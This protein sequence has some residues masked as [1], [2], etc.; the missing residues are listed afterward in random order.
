MYRL[1]VNLKINKF[2]KTFGLFM[3]LFLFIT[4]VLCFGL[5]KEWSEPEIIIQSTI[6][7]YIMQQYFTEEYKNK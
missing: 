7:A 6:L 5:S 4:I 2:M 3:V 1:I